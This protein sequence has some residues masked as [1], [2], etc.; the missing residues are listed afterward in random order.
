VS[1]SSTEAE[2]KAVANATVEVMWIQTLLLE[3]GI[4]CPKQAKMW[5][6]NLGAKYMASNP[7]FHGQVKAQELHKVFYA[8]IMCLPEIRLQMD[9]RKGCQFGHLKI[10]ST[11]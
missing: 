11:I 5:C 7:V 3:I 1:Q 2:Y 10:S 4:S 9:L 6:D 8:L